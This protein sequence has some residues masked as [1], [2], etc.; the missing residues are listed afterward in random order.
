MS[1]VELYN[2]SIKPLSTVERL[3][4]AK[5]ILGDIPDRAVVDYSEEWTEEDLQD[6]NRASWERASESLGE[7][8]DASSEAR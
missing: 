2:Q 1:V 5:L 6:A 7:A 8:G 4:L 3:Q